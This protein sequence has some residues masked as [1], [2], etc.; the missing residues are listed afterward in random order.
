MYF[1][2][3]RLVLQFFLSLLSSFSENP[4]PSEKESTLKKKCSF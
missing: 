4:V 3:F 1:A 2:S